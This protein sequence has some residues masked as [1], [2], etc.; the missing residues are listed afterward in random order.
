MTLG[1]I[2]EDDIHSA[3]SRH[4]AIISPFKQEEVGKHIRSTQFEDFDVDRKPDSY[5]CFLAV[6]HT[7][8]IIPIKFYVLVL[9]LLHCTIIHYG[10]VIFSPFVSSSC[11]VGKN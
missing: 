2:D 1:H 11:W 10:K 8:I 3:L 9:E 5:I 7:L 4:K 6:C